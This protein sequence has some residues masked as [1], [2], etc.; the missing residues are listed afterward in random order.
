[1]ESR[2]IR[3]VSDNECLLFASDRASAETEASCAEQ[4]KLRTQKR[5]TSML[6]PTIGA[7]V[8]ELEEKKQEEGNIYQ[9]RVD[10]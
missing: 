6:I 2:R 9:C 8:Y 5:V 10:G 7:F 3:H 1:M 4:D